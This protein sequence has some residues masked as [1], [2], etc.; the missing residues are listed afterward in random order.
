M[1]SKIE[2]S[3]PKNREIP[4]ENLPLGFKLS[5]DGKSAFKKFT[6]ESNGE[7]KNLI[8]NVYFPANI[9]TETQRIKIL[10]QFSDRRIQNLG[11]QSIELGLGIKFQSINFIK[12]S[13]GKLQKL[14]LY[15]YDGRVKTLDHKYFDEKQAEIQN[16]NDP[17]KLKKFERK[18]NV[19]QSIEK[20]SNSIKHVHSSQKSIHKTVEESQKLIN[21]KSSKSLPEKIAKAESLIDELKQQISD[22]REFL[23][24]WYVGERRTVDILDEYINKHKY[25]SKEQILK[26][27]EKNIFEHP[28]LHKKE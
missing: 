11:K 19:F 9:K 24:D 4:P 25:A 12:D 6:I 20:A 28:D 15:R 13:S 1:I 8:F 21:E 3:T 10:N 7:K 23:K 27:A 22:E 26:W 17:E 16:L 2:S 5:E 14:D 18:F